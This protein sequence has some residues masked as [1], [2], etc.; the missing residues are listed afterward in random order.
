MSTHHWATPETANNHTIDS[1]KQKHIA[2]DCHCATLFL[3]TE[4]LPLIAVDSCFCYP[5]IVSFREKDTRFHLN[6]LKYCLIFVSFQTCRE[7]FINSIQKYFKRIFPTTSSHKP[8][9]LTFSQPLRPSCIRLK[10]AHGKANQPFKS[11]FS[12]VSVLPWFS[13]TGSWCW[14]E[15]CCCFLDIFACCCNPAPGQRASAGTDH[16]HIQDRV[17]YRWLTFVIYFVCM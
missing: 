6:S 4:S 9:S 13:H 2:G 11:I 3:L 1:S 14:S 15:R 12:C 17:N 7:I 10:T 5:I 16:L 8:A